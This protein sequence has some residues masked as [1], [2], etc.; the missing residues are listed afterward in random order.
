[1]RLKLV[2][3][4]PKGILLNLRLAL[5]VPAGSPSTLHP[6]Q[7]PLLLLLLFLFRLVPKGVA[8]PEAGS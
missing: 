4:M 6:L 1:M 7:L 8:A 3:L 2:L 5:E